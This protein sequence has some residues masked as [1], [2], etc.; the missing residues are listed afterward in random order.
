MGFSGGFGLIIEVSA[1]LIM[2]YLILANAGGFSDAMGAVGG[3]FIGA[4]KTLQ[5]R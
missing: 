5:G 1:T 3:Q 4:V 2:M